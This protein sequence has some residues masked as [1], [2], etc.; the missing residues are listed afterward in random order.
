MKEQWWNRRS[1]NAF[2][3]EEQTHESELWTPEGRAQTMKKNWKTDFR[4][5]PPESCKKVITNYTQTKTKIKKKKT[6]EVPIHKQ[7]FQPLKTPSKWDETI[8][9]N[10]E[11][12][13]EIVLTPDARLFGIFVPH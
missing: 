8:P 11:I 13:T 5:S 4:T 12:G 10:K 3:G 9:G 6:K 2:L 7:D 1:G